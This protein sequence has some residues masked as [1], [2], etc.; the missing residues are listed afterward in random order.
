MEMNKI[1]QDN[2]L[3]YRRKLNENFDNIAEE[4]AINAFIR[5]DTITCT[6][7][8]T[9]YTLTGTFTEK[10]LGGFTSD[11][12]VYTFTSLQDLVLET[13]LKVQAISAE[14]GA[15]LTFALLLNG[16]VTIVAG[17]DISG[18]FATTVAKDLVGFSSLELTEDDT[19]EI[20][21]ASSIA[22][23]DLTGINVD[24]LAKRLN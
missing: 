6:D 10:V 14:D 5:N 22:A 21:V 2:S 24:F 19:I 15:V 1:V 23:N 8:D 3:A 4:V 20:A 11:A 17:T 12:N 18:T 9:Y 16:A 13:A 7:A